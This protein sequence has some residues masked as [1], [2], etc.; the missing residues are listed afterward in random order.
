MLSKL[1]KDIVSAL[2]EKG[3]QE[4]TE[5]QKIAIPLILEGKNVLIISPTGSGKTEAAILPVMHRI[6]NSKEPR[7]GISCIYITPLRA[8]NR[9]M[10]KRLRY[11]GEKLNIQISVR[12]GDTPQSE[13]RKQS[14]NPPDIMITTPETFQ[15]MFLGKKLKDALRHVRFV[16]VDE[17][18][19]LAGDERGA[20]LAVALERLKRLTNFQIIGLSATVGNPEEIAKFLS[21]DKEIITV[22]IR[23]K[24]I[25]NIEVRY[26]TENAD[27]V[28]AIMGCEKEYASTL[29]DIW[30]EAMKHRATLLFVNTRCT[31]EDIGM[32][33]N[34]WLKDPPIEVHHGSLSKEHR[35]K[36]ENELKEGKI[37]M[38]ICTSSLELGIDVGI[39]DL[40]IQYN[41]PR[42]VTKL[43]QR[44]GRSGHRQGAISK[45]IIY[46]ENPVELWEAGAI[47]KLMVKGWIENVKIRKKPIMVLF[48]QIVAMANSERKINAME[49]YEIVKSAYPFRD[50]TWEEFEEVLF[51]AKENKKIWYDGFEFGKSRGGNMY[52][53]DNISMIPDEKSYRVV[54]TDGKFIGLVDERFV[55][56]LNPGESFVMG[57]KTWR[58]INI[59]GEKVIV[60]YI[61]DI[62]IPPRWI[63]EEIPVPYEIAI[64]DPTMKFMNDK[65]KE[66]LEN[67]KLWKKDE[68][69]IERGENLIFVGIRGGTKGNYTLG[70]AISSLLSQKIGESVEFSITPYSI[71]FFNPHVAEK[72]IENIFK[73]LTN[74]RGLLKIVIKNSRVFKYTF[75]HVARKMGVIGKNSSITNTKIEKIANTYKNSVLYREVL[76]K[77]LHD[78]MDIENAEKILKEIQKG[79]IKIKFRKLSNEAKL[80][81]E[82]KGDLASPILATRPVLEAVHK[83]LMNEEMIL[84]CLSCKKSMHIKVKN[85][86]KAICPFCGSVRVTLL[87]PYEEKLINEIKKGNKIKASDM[88]RL[89]GISHLLRRHRRIGAMALAGRGIGLTAAARILSIPYDDELEV[90]K[91]ILKEELKYAKNRQFWD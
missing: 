84:L 45:G 77:I 52:F 21:P 89:I 30:K 25:A 33:Y 20:Q 36:V 81:L 51:F 34:L 6:V 29:I 3:I 2:Y 69:T 22:K 80:L 53:Y 82:S 64:E 87:K 32:R 35:I 67:F 68:I 18:H 78:Y 60:E 41:S 24:N 40:V 85:F 31:A 56:T 16:I 47:A 70:L 83:R 1:S 62:S 27:D 12:H 8:L 54:S 15:I 9:D 23:D 76:N 65:A 13:R 75:L 57:G 7:K 58:V 91:R 55:S 74:L 26:P 5:I 43:I 90:V 17:V 49:A 59:Y 19:E 66:K 86:E 28:A 39:V 72:D 14:L 71:A 38:L 46:A 88:E 37:K 48:N 4:P 73:K 50:L 10:L 61:M 44:V 63:G 42:Q 11:F 79:N